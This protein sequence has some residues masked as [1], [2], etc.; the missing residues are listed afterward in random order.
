MA[1]ISYFAG[2][3]LKA[4]LTGAVVKILPNPAANN[5]QL[6]I[7]LTIPPPAFNDNV[8]KP[9]HTPPISGEIQL[10]VTTLN[11]LIKT[12]VPKI[13]FTA[14]NTNVYLNLQ[15]NIKGIKINHASAL[16]KIKK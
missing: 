5:A 9:P 10:D 12:T 14:E 6:T 7:T 11:D 13:S 3:L 1:N 15:I 2:E 8:D 4:E 16:K